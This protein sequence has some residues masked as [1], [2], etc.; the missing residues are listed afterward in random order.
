VSGALVM[1]DR[2]MKRRRVG[3]EMGG[4]VDEARSLRGGRVGV[5]SAKPSRGLS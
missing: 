4:G 2:L 3:N 5:D 1:Y